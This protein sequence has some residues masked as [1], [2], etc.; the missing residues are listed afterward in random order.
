VLSAFLTVVL[1]SG[2]NGG[3]GTGEARAI[4]LPSPS[5]TYEPRNETKNGRF[6]LKPISAPVEMG[7]PYRFDLYIHCGVDHTTDFD[8]SFWDAVGPTEGDDSPRRSF[9]D[10]VDE[11]VMTLVS[12]TG[13]STWGVPVRKLSSPGIAARLRLSDV[14]D[15]G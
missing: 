12:Q 2:C 7:V 1:L 4:A 5:A 8:G 6:V 13:R 14:C 11:G 9:E 15:S 10:P 3:S